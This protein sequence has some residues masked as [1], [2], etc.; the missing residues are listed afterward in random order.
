[1]KFGGLKLWTHYLLLRVKS[2]G[3]GNTPYIV[4]TDLWIWKLKPAA[5]A[6]SLVT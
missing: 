5:L 1:M 3:E 4:A 6:L 2:K